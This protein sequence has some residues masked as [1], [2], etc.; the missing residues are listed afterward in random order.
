MQPG[1]SKGCRR[2][3][4]VIR[5]ATNGT[6]PLLAFARLAKPGVST[7]SKMWSKIARIKAIPDV[8][9]GIPEARL[10]QY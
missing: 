5:Q 7:L 10:A 4:H 8:D 3:F 1:I 6:L 9:K 2:T